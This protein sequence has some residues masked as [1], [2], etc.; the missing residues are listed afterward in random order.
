LALFPIVSIEYQKEFAMEII[1]SNPLFLAG[2]VGIAVL[3]VI[4]IVARFIFKLTIKVFTIGC[5]GILLLSLLC[6]I[7]VYLGGQQ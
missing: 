5:L 7:S 4:L 3:A 2:L 1:G 6:A